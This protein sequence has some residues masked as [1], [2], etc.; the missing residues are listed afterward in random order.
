[1]IYASTVI[2]FVDDKDFR[3]TQRLGVLENRTLSSFDSPFGALDDLY[4]QILST[5]P[6]HYPLVPILRLIDN[7][8][9]QFTP[10]ETDMVLQLEPGDTKLCLRRLHAVIFT[11]EDEDDPHPK[12]FHASFSEF[13]RER[14]RAGDFYTGD[15]AGR[16]VAVSLL[17]HLSYKYEDTV[18]NRD[19]LPAFLSGILPALYAILSQCPPSSNLVQL[20]S[21]VNYDFIWGDFKVSHWFQASIQPAL[22]W[23]NSRRH[24]ELDTHRRV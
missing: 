7:L 8:P 13:L 11:E 23:P 18:K 14:S 21:A 4:T 16:I 10:S 5:V 9:S 1:F 22:A 17:T 19:R 6:K 20:L 15:S 2:K 12:F 24:R 3:P